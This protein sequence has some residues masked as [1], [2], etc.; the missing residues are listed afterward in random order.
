MGRPGRSDMRNFREIFTFKYDYYCIYFPRILSHMTN[1]A[2]L[3]QCTLEQ[4]YDYA[5]SLLAEFSKS[6]RF[7]AFPFLPDAN[8]NGDFP[9]EFFTSTSAPCLRRIRAILC[10][11]RRDDRCNGVSWSLFR[12]FTS[13]P[14]SSNRCA[15][16][17]TLP[18][19][20]FE[21]MA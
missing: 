14:R 1:N 11:R 19:W 10:N 7:I 16:Q 6:N 21:T 4:T 5:S 3:H 8:C 18:G 12:A 9:S 2:S 13:A 17:T 15:R 20:L